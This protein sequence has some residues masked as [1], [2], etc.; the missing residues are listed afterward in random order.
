VPQVRAGF[1][2]PRCALRGASNP[3][4]WGTLHSVLHL[5]G[6]KPGA[7]F[8]F[9]LPASDG[10][11]RSQRTRR[12]R[13]QHGY[14]GAETEAVCGASFARVRPTCPCAQPHTLSLH[15]DMHHTHRARRDHARRGHSRIPVRH[16]HA[17]ITN[18]FDRVRALLSYRAGREQAM[19]CPI[20]PIRS[21]S[22]S[23]SCNTRQSSCQRKKELVLRRN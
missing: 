3:A 8:G 1:A 15:A 9:L 14:L 17:L 12:R 22:V 13:G 21:E 18:T 10:R 2:A 23:P 4:R 19:R 16:V 7:D 20:V 11:W 5:H 6:S